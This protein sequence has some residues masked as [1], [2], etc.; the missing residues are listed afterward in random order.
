MNFLRLLSEEWSEDIIRTG[1]LGALLVGVTK[2]N[3]T[4]GDLF[5]GAVIGV[6]VTITQKVVVDYLERQ[7]EEEAEAR[8]VVDAEDTVGIQ[9]LQVR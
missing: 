5:K 8:D 4:A 7:V 3:P 2:E 9:A 1:F 6:G